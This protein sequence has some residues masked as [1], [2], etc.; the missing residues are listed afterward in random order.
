M[1]FWVDA[2]R[3]HSVALSGELKHDVRF[4][5]LQVF[6]PAQIDMLCKPSKAVSSD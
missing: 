5:Q 3:E 6:E 1:D 2:F 4:C